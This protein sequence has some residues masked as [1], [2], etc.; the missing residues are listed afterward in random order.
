MGS[1]VELA[2]R[3]AGMA[4]GVGGIPETRIQDAVRYAHPR[5]RRKTWFIAR[6]QSVEGKRAAT[7]IGAYFQFG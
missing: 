1:D 7:P 2:E 6:T 3:S 5:H 4:M